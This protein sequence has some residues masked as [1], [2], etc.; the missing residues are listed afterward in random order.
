MQRGSRWPSHSTIGCT[1]VCSDMVRSMTI[2][3]VLVVENGES[4]LSQ[5]PESGAATRRGPQQRACTA[6]SR[7]GAA[8]VGTRIQARERSTAFS[9]PRHHCSRRR[10]C[11]TAGAADRL[12][13][14]IRAW[15]AGLVCTAPT[16][17]QPVATLQPRPST[18]PDSTGDGVTQIC[19]SHQGR[20]WRALA[21]FILPL[22]PRPA[23]PR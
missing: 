11:A 14:R 4:E 6:E 7:G 18:P 15:P 1:V 2:A 3:F 16:R 9:T 21:Q 8:A 13:A 20:T 17:T 23:T 19:G 22:G 10:R 5:K 12:I